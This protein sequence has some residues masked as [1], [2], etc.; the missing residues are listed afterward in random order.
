MR[1]DVEYLRED[2]DDD[3]PLLTS[4]RPLGL[5]REHSMVEQ[6]EVQLRVPFASKLGLGPSLQYCVES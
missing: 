4:N 2:I 5:R 3:A 1:V 6:S